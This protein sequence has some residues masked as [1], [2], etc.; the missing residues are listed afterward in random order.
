[1][2]SDSTQN[3]FT[4]SVFTENSPGVLHRITSIF[5]R[6]K[7]NIESLTVSETEEHDIS[8]FTIVVEG[9]EDAVQKIVNQISRVI[10]VRRAYASRNSDLVYKEIAF[11]KLR[12]PLPERKPEIDALVERHGGAFVYTNGTSLIVQKTGSEDEIKA[13][14]LLLQPYEIEEFIRSGRIALRKEI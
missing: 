10:E 6:R 12:M 9:D 14:Y 5:T 8:R 7:T 2:I 1:M 3:T 4:I 11:I 13:L